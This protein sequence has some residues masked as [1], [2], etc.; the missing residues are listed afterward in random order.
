MWPLDKFMKKNVLVT[1]LAG[2]LFETMTDDTKKRIE[3]CGTALLHALAIAPLY[4]VM[5]V[6]EDGQVQTIHKDMTTL[7][8]LRGED[9]HQIAKL[10]TGILEKVEKA[11]APD[12]LDKK[13]CVPLVVAQSDYMSQSKADE[14]VLSCSLLIKWLPPKTEVNVPVRR[15]SLRT[16]RIA[17]RENPVCTGVFT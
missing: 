5:H 6:S 9:R 11:P 2:F 17:V 13:Q 14:G 7:N 12:G 10:V 16:V 4:Q 8:P 15:D 3:L 1:Q